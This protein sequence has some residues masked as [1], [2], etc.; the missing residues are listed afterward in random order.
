MNSGI[1][2]KAQKAAQQYK[3]EEYIENVELAREEVALD[4]LGAVNLDDLI[5]KIYQ[6]EI[7]PPQAITKLSEDEN[8]AKMLTK[9]GLLF[10]ITV[11]KTEY[12]GKGEEVPS[13]P[14]IK[15]GDI[16]FDLSQKGWTNENVEVSITMNEKYDTD[17]F[18]LQYS[19]DETKWDDYTSPIEVSENNTTI[20][21]TIR[22]AIGEINGSA[23]QK[24]TTIDKNNP[25]DAIIQINKKNNTSILTTD[26][27]NATITLADNNGE[28][29]GINVKESKWVLNTDSNETIDESNFKNTFTEDNTTQNITFPAGEAGTFYIHVLTLDNAKNKT[30]T[31]SDAIVVKGVQEVL[32]LDK[33]FVLI[34]GA[35]SPDNTSDY[36]NLKVNTTYRI[37]FD[38]R[39]E[40][41]TNKFDFDLWPDEL[42]QEY[43]VATTETQHFIWETKSDQPKMSNCKLRFFDDIRDQDGESNITITN[44]KI[45]EIQ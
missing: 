11:D 37:E 45:Y 6:N 44:I 42:P 26:T 35:N 41:G 13:P 24:I 2:K 20:Y 17:K 36:L 23:S 18:T 7:V 19:Y 16:N 43:A 30:Q 4:N 10:L 25:K 15:N 28:E 8:K 29:S 39:C 40:S 34:G 22:N 1:F 12:I 5:N 27:V 14:N 31:V 9:E 33:G 38:Y 32:N 21:A 3:I